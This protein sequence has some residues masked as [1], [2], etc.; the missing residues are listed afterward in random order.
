MASNMPSDRIEDDI[1]YE[2]EDEIDN[3]PEDEIQINISDIGNIKNIIHVDIYL[4]MRHIAILLPR[5]TLNLYYTYSYTIANPESLKYEMFK[6]FLT[7]IILSWILGIICESFIIKEIICNY[8]QSFDLLVWNYIQYRNVMKFPFYIF[9]YDIII[10]ICFGIYFIVKCSPL[11]KCSDYSEFDGPANYNACISMKLISITT[12]AILY[13]MIF[14]SIVGICYVCYKLEKKKRTIHNI[15]K[16]TL[17]L[18]DIRYISIDTECAICQTTAND[19]KTKAWTILH[20]N[21]KYHIL[22]IA[23]AIQYSHRKCP[24]CRENM[25]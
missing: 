9:Q 8:G 22:C 4:L 21:H 3:E 1:P 6:M 20:C 2:I 19:N 5:I 11:A 16:K 17:E 23:E 24:L 18:C 10:L 12:Y 13:Y 15:F 14:I 7:Y 25:V